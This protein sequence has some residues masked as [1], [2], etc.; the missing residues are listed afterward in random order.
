V[1]G[2]FLVLLVKR[3][4][5]SDYFMPPGDTLLGEEDRAVIAVKSGDIRTI[6]KFAGRK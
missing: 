1:P 4:G 2:E 6:R 3:K 5:E